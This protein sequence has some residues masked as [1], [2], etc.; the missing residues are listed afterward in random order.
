MRLGTAEFWRGWILRQIP[1]YNFMPLN[2]MALAKLVHFD[3]LGNREHPGHHRCAVAISMPRAMYAKPS[4]LQQ[5]FCVR[6]TSYL[7]EKVPEQTRA[8]PADQL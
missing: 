2:S 7:G 6:F 4:S 1:Y 5:I 3:V 8:A